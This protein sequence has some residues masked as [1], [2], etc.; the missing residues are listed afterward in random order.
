M[1]PLSAIFRPDDM[2]PAT[3]QF[4][5]RVEHRRDS[6][7]IQPKAM[8][9]AKGRQV[10]PATPRCYADRQEQ[11]MNQ[12]LKKAIREV[13]ALPEDEQEELGRALMKM[14]VRKKIDAM[15]AQAEARG[16]SIPHEKVM[17]E[18]RAKYGG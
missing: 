16:G 1:A 6:G 17:A 14:A 9:V 11:A 2:R 18:L 3:R 7:V 12:T 4:G 15:L 13:E 8:V 10:C 5:N